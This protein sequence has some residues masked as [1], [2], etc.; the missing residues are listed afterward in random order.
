MRVQL[1]VAGVCLFGSAWFVEVDG[2]T[3]DKKPAPKIVKGVVSPSVI[4]STTITKTAPGK[5][6]APEKS[7]F[8]DLVKN[9]SPNWKM[10]PGQTAAVNKLLAGQQPLSAP[11][12]QQLSDL[13]F[14]A[15]DAGLSQ[16]D[17][18]ALSYLLLDEAARQSSTTSTSTAAVERNGPLFLR[19]Y[20]NTGERL[21][22]W[23]QLLPDAQATSAKESQSKETAKVL[24]EPI[25]YVLESGKAYDLQK[26][27]K[28]LQ[29]SAIHIWAVS[30]TRSWAAHRDQE[31]PLTMQASKSKTYTLTFSK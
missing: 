2:Q 10:A 23:V 31:L 6:K 30:P 16:E 12:R 25:P 24:P 9:S 1:V 26:D 11:E 20:N 15:K 8:R 13:L 5:F 18:A 21:K 22:V 27:G 19:I 17:E 29:A 4:Q 28:R 3:K 14:N 7:K